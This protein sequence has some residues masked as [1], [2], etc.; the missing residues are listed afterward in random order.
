MVFAGFLIILI[1][2]PFSSSKRRSTSKDGY[3]DLVRLRGL[4]EEIPVFACM[5]FTMFSNSSWLKNFPLR[6]ARFNADAS[7]AIVR[8]AR[9][10]FNL[11]IAPK[12]PARWLWSNIT[13]EPLKRALSHLSTS[14][15]LAIPPVTTVMPSRGLPRSRV[16]TMVPAMLLQSPL[17]NASLL[18]PSCW[19]WIRSDLANTLHRAAI[20]GGSPSYMKLSSL[21]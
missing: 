11:Y 17:H 20:E 1:S 5:V 6:Y 13:I 7:S 10:P 3:R 15:F 14:L 16:W 18:Y 12:A 4:R 2:L 21:S 19:R 8:F 9:L